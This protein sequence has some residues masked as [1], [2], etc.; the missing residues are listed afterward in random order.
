MINLIKLKAII[1]F[2]SLI[3]FNNSFGETFKALKK[4]MVARKRVLRCDSSESV[5]GK[6][7]LAMT[8]STTTIP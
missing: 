8:P 5:L 4:K 3:V 2:G 1:V 6:R 7:K